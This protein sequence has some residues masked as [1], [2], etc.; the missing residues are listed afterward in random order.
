MRIDV[1]EL[2]P[3]RAILGAVDPS[4][5]IYLFGSRADERSRGGDIDL[6]LEATKPIDLGTALLLKYRLSAACDTKVDLLVKSPEDRDQPIHQIARQGV[7][8]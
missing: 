7:R 5:S 3:I 4:D 2:Q 1:T 6:L 8:L